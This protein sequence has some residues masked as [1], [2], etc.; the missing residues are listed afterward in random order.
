MFPPSSRFLP[1]QQQS[2]SLQTNLLT[3]RMPSSSSSSISSPHTDTFSLR[4]GGQTQKYLNDLKKAIE[5]KVPDQPLIVE[6]LIYSMKLESGH[7][8]AWYTLPGIREKLEDLA[9]AH[10]VDHV[11]LQ[12]QHQIGPRKGWNK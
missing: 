5:A 6:N 9:V 1:N 8:K 4:F 12:E 7:N 3:K 2:V 11:E 10:E